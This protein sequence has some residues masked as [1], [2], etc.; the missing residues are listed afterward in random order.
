MATELNT[1]ISINATP[2]KVWNILMDFNLYPRWNPFIRSISGIAEK[3]KQLTVTMLAPGKNAM[4]FKPMV[5]LAEPFKTFRWKGHLVV[6]GLFDGEHI[7]ELREQND[8][9]TLFIQREKFGGLL[10][11]LF[12][13]M[14]NNNTRRGFE[15]M[16]IELKKQCEA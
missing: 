3:G 2:Q 5:L 15:L 11:P 8:G 7:F 14:L 9:T 6:P 1:S 12:K 13:K 16:N 4:T 10:V